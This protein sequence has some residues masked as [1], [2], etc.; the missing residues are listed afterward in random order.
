MVQAF[1]AE[2]KEFEK[3]KKINKEHRE[4][5]HQCHILLTPYFFPVVEIVLAFSIGLLV[6]WGANNAFNAGV[7]ISFIMYLNL[8]FR[9]LKSNCR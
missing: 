7:I 6:W 9:P 8:L 2:D 1:A 5:Q 4:C 3:F